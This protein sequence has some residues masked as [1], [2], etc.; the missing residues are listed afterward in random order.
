MTRTIPALVAAAGLLLPLS[1][2]AVAAPVDAQI[3]G[4]IVLTDDQL[5]SLTAGQT[6]DLAL[7]LDSAV[8]RPLVWGFGFA[9][10]AI[11]KFKAHHGNPTFPWLDIPGLGVEP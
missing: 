7:L 9:I 3:A 1:A 4:P 8:E 10:A 11:L 6:G 2:A 5:D